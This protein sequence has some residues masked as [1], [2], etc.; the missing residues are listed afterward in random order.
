MGTHKIGN[1]TKGHRVWLQGTSETYGWPVGARYDVTYTANVIV[2]T[3]NADGKRKVSAGKGGVV[4]LVGKKVTQW[5]GESTECYVM[6]NPQRTQI[7]IV[8]E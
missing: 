6:R 7:L 3:L 8:A 5:A 1:T 4:D 2:L